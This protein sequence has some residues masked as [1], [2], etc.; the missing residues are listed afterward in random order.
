M[1]AHGMTVRPQDQVNRI[2]Q[3]SIEIEQERGQRPRAD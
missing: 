3:R 2:D 1:G